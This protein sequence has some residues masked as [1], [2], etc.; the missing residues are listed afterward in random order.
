MYQITKNLVVHNE[1]EKKIIISPY[2]SQSNED[3][4]VICIDFCTPGEKLFQMHRDDAEELANAILY[5][6]KE[7]S[8]K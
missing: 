8:P 4:G 3:T 5:Y 2:F 7:V 6:L 1:I